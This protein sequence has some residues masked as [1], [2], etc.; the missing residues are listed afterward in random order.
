MLSAILQ[1]EFDLTWNAWFSRV[2]TESNKA[3][4][5][6]RGQIQA[7]LDQ[8]IHQQQVDQTLLWEQMLELATR[9]GIDQHQDALV[10]KKKVALRGQLDEG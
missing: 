2:P 1:L 8:T 5:P 9:G 3:D 10:G 4:D 7:L 6:S